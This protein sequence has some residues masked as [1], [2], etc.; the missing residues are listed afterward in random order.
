M[1]ALPDDN[2]TGEADPNIQDLVKYG[3]RNEYCQPILF[4]T[5]F[6]RNIDH[7]VG[8]GTVSIKSVFRIC[9]LSVFY[10]YSKTDS[11]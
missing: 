4:G 9:I 6:E 8:T 5:G 10:Y 1:P 3:P 7:E 2:R 11:R